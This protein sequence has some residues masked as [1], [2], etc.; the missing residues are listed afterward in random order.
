MTE[1]YREAD[2]RF[3]ILDYDGT[4]V[5]YAPR[6]QDAMPSASLLSMLG[7]LARDPANCLA[8]VSGRHRSDLEG[9]F[10]EIEGLWLAAE[11]GAVV[12]PP[13]S[14]EWEPLRSSI[15]VDWK[16]RVYPVLEHFVDRTP[17]SFIEEKDYSL[18]WHYRMSDPDFGEWLANELV[19]TME[20]M[21][22]ATELRAVRGVKSIEVRLAW[23]HKGE[24]VTR[25]TESCTEPQFYFAA[26]DDRTDEDIFERLPPEAWTVHV[27]E[28]R[29]QARF[30]LPDSAAVHAVLR[31]F[32]DSAAR[33]AQASGATAAD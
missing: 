27:G 17:G 15:P 25:L 30:R 19:A 10:G 6:P 13:G 23:A 33:A 11:H 24:L 20:E 1:A 32:V 22:A 2:A 31:A 12:R 5:S 7:T 4:L 14:H 8:I 28:R 18:V 26:G 16:E 3:L 21:L 9:W 29:S